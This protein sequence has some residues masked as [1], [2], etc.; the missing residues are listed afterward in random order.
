MRSTGRASLGLAALPL[1]IFCFFTGGYLV[2]LRTFGRGARSSVLRTLLSVLM[3]GA[4]GPLVRDS[5]LSPDFLEQMSSVMG[6]STAHW[7][8]RRSPHLAH[9]G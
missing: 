4:R 1:S 2:W 9:W 5:G 7:C 6:S 3:I 8:G